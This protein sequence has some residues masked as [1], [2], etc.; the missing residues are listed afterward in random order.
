MLYWLG[1]LTLTLAGLYPDHQ[2]LDPHCGPPDAPEMYNVLLFF[3]TRFYR[4]TGRIYL[5][6]FMIASMA[7]WFTAAGSVIA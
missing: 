6:A 1:M 4:R 3:L 5:G 2:A 7:I